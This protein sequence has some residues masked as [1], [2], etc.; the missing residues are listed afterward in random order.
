MRLIIF[1]KKSKKSLSYQKKDE[2]RHE[3]QFYFWYDNDLGH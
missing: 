1:I 2:R 3:G